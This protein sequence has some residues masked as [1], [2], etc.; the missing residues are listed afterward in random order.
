[1]S[2]VYIY[3][4]TLIVT[5]MVYN[6]QQYRA[7]QICAW[8]IGIHLFSKSDVN[9]WWELNDKKSF[10]FD[11]INKFSSW[12]ERVIVWN[13]P[14]NENIGSYIIRQKRYMW[15]WVGMVVYQQAPGQVFKLGWCSLFNLETRDITRENGGGWQESRP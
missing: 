10:I 14:N 5:I 9:V 8:K 6:D 4:I 15:G 3:Q 1:M 13:L 2:H 7:K 11:Q 12:S